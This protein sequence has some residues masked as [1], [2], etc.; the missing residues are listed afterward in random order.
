M[1]PV[2]FDDYKN[3]EQ[4]F[5]INYQ[6][7]HIRDKNIIFLEDRSKGI[8]DYYV[9]NDP[10]TYTSV[11][12]LYKKF[13]PD[14]DEDKII[15]NMMAKQNWCD[16]KYFNMTKEEIKQQW[17]NTRDEACALG[18]KMH[19]DIE[20]HINYLPVDNNTSEFGYF[21]NFYENIHKNFPGFYPYR[22]EWR[23]YDEEHKIAGSIDF[24]LKHIVTGQIALVDWKRTTKLK[25]ISRYE[26]GYYPFEKYPHCSMT[27]YSLQLNIYRTILIKNYNLDITRMVLAAFHPDL[28]EYQLVE[29]GFIDIDLKQMVELRNDK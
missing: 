25:N 23:I 17:K 16:N 19:D 15:N 12:K 20:H 27:H 8:H 1:D 9:K 4:I 21:L 28:S 6:N 26:Y 2:I 29:V 13:F 24:A 7:P 18:V 14:F 22:T 3:Q 11:S 10:S 5:A